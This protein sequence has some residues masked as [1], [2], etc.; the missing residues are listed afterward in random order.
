[1]TRTEWLERVWKTATGRAL[2]S[3]TPEAAASEYEAYFAAASGDVH[4]C[5]GRE[6]CGTP[7]PSVEAAAACPGAAPGDVVYGY[8]PATVIARPVAML[9]GGPHR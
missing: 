1:M 8:G 9:V 7:H 5:A 2:V 6:C 4:E 3:A